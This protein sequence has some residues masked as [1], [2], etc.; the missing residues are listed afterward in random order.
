ML[1]R[2]LMVSCVMLIIASIPALAVSNEKAQQAF[3]LSDKNS[4]N[5]LS[6]AEFESF[7]RRMAK[8][9]NTNAARAVRFGFV[10]FRIAFGDADANGDGNVTASELQSIR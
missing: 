8:L 4:D 9:G 6:R 3:K 7:I 10:G 2:L 1:S 5:K